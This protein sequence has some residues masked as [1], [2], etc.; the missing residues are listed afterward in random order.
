MATKE[1]MSRKDM[2]EI[3][4]VAGL[5]KS[6]FQSSRTFSRLLAGEGVQNLV[7]FVNLP[8]PHPQLL[9]HWERGERLISVHKRRVAED[10]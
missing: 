7:K 8:S 3:T 6:E 1:L 2:A 10:R 4:H 9:S 5:G